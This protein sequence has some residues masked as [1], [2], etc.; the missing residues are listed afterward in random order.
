MSEDNEELFVI[1]VAARLSG[2][3]AQ[4]LRAYDRIGLVT[5]QRTSGGGRRYSRDDID[6]LRWIQHLSQ[7][8]GVNLAGIRTIIQLQREKSE[9]EEALQQVLEENTKLRSEVSHL[10]R[11]Q[12]SGGELVHVPR[13]TAVVLWK[14]H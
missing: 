6:L 3:H 7:E 8:E 4:T 10:S 11:T 5:P 1:S 12:R 13:S 14:R 9:V 2:M